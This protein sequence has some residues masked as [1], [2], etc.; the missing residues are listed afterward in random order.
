M[1]CA[2]WFCYSKLWWKILVHSSLKHWIWKSSW[3]ASDQ[4]P[5]KS[6]IELEP[7]LRMVASVDTIL[8]VICL[9]L[10]QIW[11]FT[12]RATRETKRDRQPRG[13]AALRLLLSLVAPC[14][15]SPTQECGLP[16]RAPNSKDDWLQSQS[17]ASTDFFVYAPYDRQP[18]PWIAWPKLI[19]LH[20]TLVERNDSSQAKCPS[21]RFKNVPQIMNYIKSFKNIT[22]QRAIRESTNWKGNNLPSCLRA[23]AKAERLN[24]FPA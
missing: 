1:R 18:Y 22:P 12:L 9:D 5:Q 20:V 11:S 24:L 13:N 8:N 4:L 19:V 3:Q 17:K 10:C 15:D 7:G 14:F 23:R 16:D 2:F 6:A 21:S